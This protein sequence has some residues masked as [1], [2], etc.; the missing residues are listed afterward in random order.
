MRPPR[1]TLQDLEV[2]WKS[3]IHE[4]LPFLHSNS[5]HG[6]DLESMQAC[7]S[8]AASH[9][10]FLP[11]RSPEQAVAEALWGPFESDVPDWK[12]FWKDHARE[13]LRLATTEAVSADQILSHQV[14]CLADL[15]DDSPLFLSVSETVSRILAI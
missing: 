4:T 2:A 11:S 5:D 10:G 14:S 7:T 8:W 15:P 12:T 1:T 3:N 6:A 9:L 13:T